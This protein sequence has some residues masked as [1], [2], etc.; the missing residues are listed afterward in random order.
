MVF[1][2]QCGYQLVPGDT[3]C[4]RCGA[5][6]EVDLI[7][8]DPGT[9]NPTE[10]SR[11]ITERAPTQSAAPPNRGNSAPWQS[12][13]EP[14]GPLILGPGTPN[15]QFANEPTA[16][17]SAQNYAPQPSY[18]NYP[19]GY[20]P[21]PGA[22]GLGYN[23]AGYQSYQAGQSAVI[24]EIVAASQRGKVISLVLILFGLLLLTGAIV[25]FLLNQQGIIFPA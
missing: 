6:T 18:P 16:M 11:A 22:T 2:G 15:S 7:D 14:A 9:Y 1:C 10:I 3:I 8:H 19:P 20:P 23:P 13:A 17:M 24:A 25:V 5:K 12:Q 4:P 21:Q